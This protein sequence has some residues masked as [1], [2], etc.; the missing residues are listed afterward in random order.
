MAVRTLDTRESEKGIAYDHRPPHGVPFEPY[1]A[2]DTIIRELTP[3]PAPGQPNAVALPLHDCEQLDL[4]ATM[5]EDGFDSRW[6]VRCIEKRC[7]GGA[8]K[9][10]EPANGR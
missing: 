2:S 4:D 8:A 7:S 9:A 10:A 3:V 1:I 6:L 5:F